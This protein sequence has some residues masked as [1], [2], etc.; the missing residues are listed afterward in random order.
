MVKPTHP[1]VNFS[2][3]IV[4]ALRWA[5]SVVTKLLKS[6]LLCNETCCL[7]TPAVTLVACKEELKLAVD[8]R[9][10]LRKAAGD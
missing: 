2:D 1:G 6:V 8:V 9:A 3:G 10:R 5:L 4:T 7:G